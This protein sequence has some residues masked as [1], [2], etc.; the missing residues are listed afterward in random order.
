MHGISYDIAHMLAGLLV[1]L[2]FLMLY[3][4]RLVPLLNVLAAHAFVLAL[5]VAW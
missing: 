2:S 4:V 5:S 3:Q 1:L